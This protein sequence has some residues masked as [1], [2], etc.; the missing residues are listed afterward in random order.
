MEETQ[1][2]LW[3]WSGETWY[4]VEEDIRSQEEAERYVSQVCLTTGIYVI[5]PTGIHPAQEPS[6]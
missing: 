5:L 3:D 6:E 4:L 2:A 1:Y